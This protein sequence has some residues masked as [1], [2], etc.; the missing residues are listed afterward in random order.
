MNSYQ[1]TID[2]WLNPCE[3]NNPEGYLETTERSVYLLCKL[4]P[5]IGFSSTIIELGCGVGRNIRSL[6]NGGYTQTV[7][8]EI[9]PVSVEIAKRRCGLDLNVREG[10][11]ETTLQDLP[12][13]SKDLTFTMATLM[14]IHPDV[15]EKT[16]DEISRITLRHI[17]TIE[18]EGHDAAKRIWARDYKIEFESRGWSQVESEQVPVE[19]GMGDYIYRM[20]E[21]GVLE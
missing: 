15:F 5:R 7:G 14:H 21:K 13:E 16:M 4:M 12:N 2:Y 6:I 1:E 9:N 8:V 18:H 20:F 17:V 3:S 10:L 11:I 19:I